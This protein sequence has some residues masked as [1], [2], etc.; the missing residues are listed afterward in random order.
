MVKMTLN[1]IGKDLTP[2]EL[3]ELDAAEK[4]NIQ[5]DEDSPDMT[6]E[7]LKQFKSVNRQNRTKQTVSIR[8]S[9]KALAFSKAYGK[10][11]TSFLSRLVDAALDDDNIVKK[12]V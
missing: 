3:L 2:E 12:C 8:L 7:M 11:Y 10:G 1:E 6:L 4:L 9:P 5:F